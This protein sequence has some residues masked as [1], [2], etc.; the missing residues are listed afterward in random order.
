MTTLVQMTVGGADYYISDSG[1]AGENF[2]H[3]FLLTNPVIRYTGEGWIKAETGKLVLARDPSNSD[4]PFNYSSGNFATMLSSPS[5]Q[6]TVKINYDD[7]DMA[8]GKTLWDGIAVFSS[9]STEAIEFNLLQSQPSETFQFQ[10]IGKF[11]IYFIGN[12]TQSRFIVYA[13]NATPDK[14]KKGDQVFIQAR[15]ESGYE[16]GGLT[17]NTLATLVSDA[18]FYASSPY[19]LWS[20]TTDID[21]SA[22]SNE[23]LNMQVAALSSPFFNR[24]PT[25]AAPTWWIHKILPNTR[26]HLSDRSFKRE[27]PDER[28]M[29]EGYD[30]KDWIVMASN[31]TDSP[32]VNFFEDGDSITTTNTELYGGAST[33]FKYRKSDGTD[34]DGTLTF[35]LPSGSGDFTINDVAESRL[36]TIDISKAPNADDGDLSAIDL[37][38]NN[39]R[40]YEFIDR[41]AQATNYQ[42]YKG[43]PESVASPF[44]GG[45]ISESSVADDPFEI[46][47]DLTLAADLI[48]GGGVQATVFL[49]DRA[50]SPGTTSISDEEIISVRY[51]NPFPTQNVQTQ[52][53]QFEE[54]GSSSNNNYAFYSDSFT[55]NS[56][57]S[58]TQMG[59]TEQVEQMADR[60]A[61]QQNYLDAIL[62][63]KTK[64][65]VSVRIDSI[66]RSI[67]PGDNLTFTERDAP[68]TVSSLLVRGITYDLQQEETTFFGD[69]TIT[70]IEVE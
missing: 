30:G 66:N 23:F 20:M 46:E 54:V 10:Y 8:D 25:D 39:E 36:G 29:K 52:M 7:E 35:E 59:R 40:S 11:P 64:S 19:T 48:I 6:Y 45:T 51:E 62:D 33:G 27:I 4:H 2:W 24:F 12:E 15:F 67:K 18:S 61:A 22:Y 16:I 56:F 1:F 32:S 69:A 50:N 28:H 37:M 42:F 38:I 14:F 34:Y 55:L 58:D 68:V 21:R 53:T 43:F 49:I 57:N 5:T 44:S 3:P 17:P 60:I 13:A 26:V 70:T 9:I 41:V 31:I 63:S 47:G 65:K